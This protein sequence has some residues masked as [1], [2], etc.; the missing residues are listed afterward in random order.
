MIHFQRSLETDPDYYAWLCHCQIPC[1][2]L[3][4]SFIHHRPHQS[5]YTEWACLW[6]F[7][8]G[9]G[10]QNHVRLDLMLV[11]AQNHGRISSASARYRE[12]IK[13]L[14]CFTSQTVT[15]LALAHYCSRP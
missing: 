4:I 1:P 13:L 10:K 14:H 6:L 7:S 5:T 9:V 11:H 15:V 2:A 8:F 3:N 12:Q